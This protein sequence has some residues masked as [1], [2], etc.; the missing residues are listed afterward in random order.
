MPATEPPERRIHV[1]SLDAPIACTLAG[2]DMAVRIEE[3]RRTLADVERREPI[4]GGIRLV[5][6]SPAPLAE[7]TRLA[8]AEHGCCS[9]FSFAITIDGRGTALEVSAP[10]DGRS[11]L[12]AVFGAA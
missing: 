9:F 6:R 4:P 1:A 12:D 7:I 3:W 8:E 5:F 11:L 10:D 2:D